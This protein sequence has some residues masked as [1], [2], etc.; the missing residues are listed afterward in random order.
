VNAEL[1]RGDSS[2]DG[3]ADSL[4]EEIPRHTRPFRAW[5]A[6]QEREAGP[7]LW[8]RFVGWLR[9]LFSRKDDDEEEFDFDA[10]PP[11]E[12]ETASEII[13]V[14][15]DEPVVEEIVAV[16]EVEVVEAVVVVEEE[17][18][19]PEALSGADAL[20]DAP[21]VSEAAAAATPTLEAQ[22]FAGVWSPRDETPAAEPMAAAEEPKKKGFFARLFSRKKKD[23]DE[24]HEDAAAWESELEGEGREEV[25]TLEPAD[26]DFADDAA[27]A[28]VPAPDDFAEPVAA[29]A[30]DDF[31]EPTVA[32]APAAD[33]FADAITA[34]SPMV[35]DFAVERPAS[36]PSLDHSAEDAASLAALLGSVAPTDDEPAL[37]DDKPTVPLDVAP[38][39]PEPKKAGFFSSL[40]K[41]VSRSQFMPKIAEP[42]TEPEPAPALESEAATDSIDELFED[43]PAIG[44][45]AAETAEDLTLIEPP[46]AA[47]E[48][49]AR[50]GPPATPAVEQAEVETPAGDEFGET[51]PTPMPAVPHPLAAKASASE[52]EST[53]PFPAFRDARDDFD[54]EPQDT[55]RP[56]EKVEIPAMDE[57]EKTDEFEVVPPPTEGATA[58][59]RQVAGFFGRLFGKKAE[60]TPVSGE[61]AATPPPPADDKIPF[62][63]AKFRT[64]YNEVIRDKHQKSDVASGFATAVMGSTGVSDTN[65]P[66]F[67]A[68]LL[69]KRL[70]EMLELQAAESN[71]TG[72]DAAKYYP[73][74]QYAMV[75]LADETFATTDWPGRSAWHKHMLEPRMYGT[76]GADLEFFKRIDKLLKEAPNEKGARD[77]ARLYLMVI[78]SG[79]RGKYRVPNLRRPLAEY[80]RRLYEFSHQADALDLY[81]KERRMLPE[82][83][84][85]TM[86]SRAVGRF[87]SAQKWIATVLILVILYLGMSHYAWNRL[88]R[89]LTEIMSRIDTTDTAGRTP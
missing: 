28:A 53:Q 40:L 89:D 4:A 77:L 57:G 15:D 22:D 72:G 85:H 52:L 31:A 1:D 9:G 67:A 35:E 20:W 78:A 81:S 84:E 74:A 50:W 61:G 29:P 44:E 86:E 49:A 62:V 66:E 6:A 45:P 73:E 34:A 38:T 59:T 56:T 80:R 43:A 70:S 30:E 82:A 13:E 69:S 63:L 83:M 23:E 14:A 71:W 64:F 41:R 51:V 33:D 58:E 65:D 8:A 47:E 10:E 68:Q 42:E 76:R 55:G 79:F 88:S 48:L 75:A 54:D 26:A 18:A 46:E 11:A 60:P 2:I 16:E 24:V 7:S 5:G 21:Q 12:I 27:A 37:I 3:E 39:A 32:A 87:T 17:H 25:S 36:T 19:G